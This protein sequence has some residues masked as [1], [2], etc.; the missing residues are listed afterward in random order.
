MLKYRNTLILLIVLIVALISVRFF[1]YLGIW[2]YVGIVI[3][4]I[5]LIIIGAIRISMNFYLVSQC[6]GDRTKKA[7]AL[8]FD[9]GPDRTATP[10]VLDVLKAHGVEAGFFVVGSK[11]MGNPELVKRIDREGHIIGGHSFSHLFLFDLLSTRKMMEELSLTRDVIQQ[12]TGKRP[13]LFRPPYSVTN[14]ALAKAVKRLGLVSIG[15][16]LK[17]KDTVI[18][19]EEVLLK[20]LKKNV[21]PGDVILFHDPRKLVPGVLA[22]F[23]VYLRGQGFD[24]ARPDRLLNVKPYEHE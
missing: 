18:E 15:W 21:R 14:P 24:I 23:I 5:I 17:S 10:P 22:R 20:R 2:W 12:A 19:D 1:V 7:V 9:D 6:Y 16:S 3:A 13:R 11:T 4:W 8:T